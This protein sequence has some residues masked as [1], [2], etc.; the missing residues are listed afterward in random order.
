[1]PEPPMAV[2]GHEPVGGIT[3]GSGQDAEDGGESPRPSQMP[4][5]LD[6][7]VRADEALAL[8]DEEEGVWTVGVQS[9]GPIDLPAQ[10]GLDGE[11]AEASGAVA[12]KDERHGGV[13]EVARPVEQQDVGMGERWEVPGAWVHEVSRTSCPG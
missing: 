12:R 9:G 10:P 2:L 3:Q 4:G 7:G 1:M 11:V 5:E 6:H 8:G 13:A